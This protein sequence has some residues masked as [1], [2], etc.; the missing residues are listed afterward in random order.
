MG[1]E[2]L[3]KAG[4][5]ERQWIVGAVDTGGLGPAGQLV[6]TRALFGFGERPVQRGDRR[7]LPAFLPVLM[8]SF[9][10]IPGTGTSL[11]FRAR[12]ARYVLVVAES[13]CVDRRPWK[14]ERYACGVVP[15]T[16]RKRS[17]KAVG[18]PNP[19]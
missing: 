2:T 12:A 18:D 7:L 6:V 13:G 16:R 10:A 5:L 3:T 11:A 1:P 8:V 4:F 17:L 14:A 9:F 19:A 15:T